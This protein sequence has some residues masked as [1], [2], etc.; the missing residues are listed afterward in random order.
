MDIK[1]SATRDDTRCCDAQSKSLKQ[2]QHLWVS[3]KQA[4]LQCLLLFLQKNLYSVVLSEILKGKGKSKQREKE[5]RMGCRFLPEL[6]LKACPVQ[7]EARPTRSDLLKGAYGTC[8][9]WDGTLSAAGPHPLRFS[10]TSGT[11]KA[12]AMIKQMSAPPQPARQSPRSSLRFSND[13]ALK[14]TETETERN[15][16]TTETSTAG[17]RSYAV[18]RPKRDKTRQG[19]LP[20]E[21]NG[22]KIGLQG[23]RRWPPAGC[24]SPNRKLFVVAATRG[25]LTDL[26]WFAFS[27]HII[28]LSAQSWNFAVVCCCCWWGA[29]FFL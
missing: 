12:N 4:G 8:S 28:I 23:E 11:A 3:K 14:S 26:F 17:A 1:S 16:E 10:A 2:E 19:R 24:F 22:D 7:S 9:S 18:C 27:T 6:Y 29:F 13:N 20:G 15:R 25:S 21:T 5:R